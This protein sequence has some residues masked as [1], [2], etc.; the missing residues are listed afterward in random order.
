MFNL[1]AGLSRYVAGVALAAALFL[2]GVATES[3]AATAA[4]CEAEWAQS[5]ADDTCSNEQ[6]SASGDDCTITALCT[7]SDG[8]SRSDSVT[9]NLSSVS[10]LNN[11]N[12]TIWWNCQ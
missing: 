11:C 4:Q 3:Q 9:S 2:L 8:S 6:I 1:N 10:G 5:S 12:G 7:M